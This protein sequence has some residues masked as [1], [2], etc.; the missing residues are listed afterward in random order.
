MRR[1]F[2]VALLLCIVPSCAAEPRRGAVSEPKEP[3]ASAGAQ[4]PVTSAGQATRRERDAAPRPEPGVLTRPLIA[5]ADAD[6]RI[7]AIDDGDLVPATRPVTQP[8]TRGTLTDRVKDDLGQPP[9]A[10]PEKAA[11]ATG[12][13]TRA[14]ERVESPTTR[15]IAEA[16]ATVPTTS[17]I[18][19]VPRTTV[20]TT[21]AVAE[22][23]TTSPSTRAIAEAPAT[24][25]P[26]TRAVAEAPTTSPSAP[27]VAATPSTSPA[28]A[29]AA[30]PAT[31]PAVAGT[32]VSGGRLVETPT[33]ADAPGD[34][35]AEPA[36][37]SHHD[38]AAPSLPVTGTDYGRTL[39]ILVIALFL[40]ALVIGPII[41][42]NLPRE[43]PPVAHSHDEPPG[44]SG[45]H[46]ATGQLDPP[47]HGH[48]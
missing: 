37:H 22:A 40:A 21:S 14:S 4:A 3:P 28:I 43:A 24:T 41:R 7:V 9:A 47:G 13:T 48:H 15:A 5:L 6:G 46:G 18:A 17:A 16:P 12:P 35:P 33:G 44:A 8:A 26:T 29:V 32:S 42:A 27:D 2:M 25:A 38:A 45:H 31:Q 39:V 30:A 19:E 20:P 23:P 11:S 36:A 10:E 34:A 1:A